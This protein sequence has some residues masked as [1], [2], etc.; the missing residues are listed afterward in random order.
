[1]LNEEQAKKIKQE[2]LK[3]IESWPENQRKAA[4]EQIEVMSPDELEQFLIKNKMIKNADEGILPDEIVEEGKQ[5]CVF[6]LI[7]QG[8]V[9]SYKLD[10]NKKALAI[11]EINPLSKGHSLVISK[12]HSKLSNQAF[13]LANKLAKRIKSK[14]KPEEV[15]IENSKVL[16]HEL[17]NIIPIYKNTKLEKKKA[18]ERE[19]IL[20]QEKL[21]TKPKA[22]KE[23]K[24]K[25]AE[26]KLSKAPKRIP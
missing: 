8:K 13:S 20:L 6:C 3:Q 11:L 25:Q 5:E 17:I 15:K 14:F 4:R 10:E 7:L 18:D 2:I 16:G 1:M 12:E 22:K 19:L 23:K 26:I 9:P 24:V 21:R